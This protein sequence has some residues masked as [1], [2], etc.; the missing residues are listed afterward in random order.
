MIPI[1]RPKLPPASRLAPYLAAID[2]VRLYSNFGPHARAFEGRLC[3]HFG[4]EGGTIATV[5]NATLGLTLALMAQGASRGALCAMPAWTFV[6]S[7]HAVALAGLVPYFV[8]VDP[9]TWA[10]D[11]LA[12]EDE[13][14]SAPTPVGAVMVVTPFGEPIDYSAWD[15]FKCRT[16]LP[17]VIDAAAAF[18]SLQV[19]Q[20]PSVVSLHATK[21]LG[22]GEGGFVASR[23]AS[24]IRSIR[25][26]SNF[27]FDGN[28]S[29]LIAGV[30]AKLSEYHAAIGLASLDMWSETRTAW[31]SV[32]G[33]YRNA[34]KNSNSIN[35]QP[36]F[37]ETCEFDVHCVDRR[38]RPRQG[39]AGIGGRRNRNAIMVGQRGAQPTG[40]CRVS[41][42]Q[43]A[44][45][46]VFGE[47]DIGPTDFSGSAE[48]SGT[49]NRGNAHC[50]RFLMKLSGA[51]SGI[52][53][54]RPRLTA[55]IPSCRL[56]LGGDIALSRMN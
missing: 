29:A 14:A 40:D 22:V 4:L 35:L 25:E 28:R 30:N 6:A 34:M 51:Y 52:K 21:I 10:L 47:N 1:L 7:A 41:A 19:G 9:V 20:T 5:A 36:G 42:S 27:G 54:Q 53:W 43:L 26:R 44:G 32:A 17:V 49:A 46:G 12:I 13:I 24:V 18:D 55:R 15:D 2:E 31:M 11:P 48:G 3:S 33:T 37:G 38:A 23:D 45:H 39:A 16:G 56:D 50:G 8:D